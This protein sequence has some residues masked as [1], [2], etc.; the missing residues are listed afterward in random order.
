MS[1]LVGDEVAAAA[2]LVGE[3]N[4]LALG[5]A[6]VDGEADRVDG[7]AGAPR[8]LERVLEVEAAHF[9]LAVREQQ[10][11]A[12][13][14]DAAEVVEREHQA[15]V[16]RGLT[17]GGESL[18]AAAQER[19]VV[20]ELDGEVGEAVEGDDGGTVARRDRLLEEA[21]RGEAR[22]LERAAHRRRVVEQDGGVK[23]QV[24][25]AVEARPPLALLR[26][27]AP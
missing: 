7:D 11:R 19:R 9:V 3:P 26:P 27:R 22:L 16:E 13:A 25:D 2:G 10:D 14:G 18:E 6:V 17:L 8:V 24:L 4:Q 21:Q 12:L 23:R 1:L 5:R 20:G 15:V